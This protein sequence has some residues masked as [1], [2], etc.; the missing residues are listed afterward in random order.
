[1]EVAE[2]AERYAD[3]TILVVEDNPVNQEV[4][5]G[6]LEKLGFT[7]ISA[8]NGQE[9]LDRLEQGDI[10]LVLM[11]CQMPVLDGYSATRQL[12]ER[13]SNSGAEHTPVIAL[14][15]NAMQGDTE[16]CLNA[17]MDD[18]LAK[19]FEPA[20]LEEILLDWLEHRPQLQD[21]S[22]TPIAAAGGGK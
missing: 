15:A 7:A 14:T 11:D 3:V 8:D 20:R 12:R 18:Y 16:K 4:A 21:E 5:L 10:S 19:P 6:M 17:G 22:N 2:R 1:M 13:E 9:G